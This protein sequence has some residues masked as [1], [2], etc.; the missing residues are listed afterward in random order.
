MLVTLP[1]M[2]TLVRLQQLKNAL[3]PISVTLSGMVMLVRLICLEKV[4][5][6]ITLVSLWI[7]QEAIDVLAVFTKTR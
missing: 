4:F 7:I 5:R 6:E 2:V 1:G 3:L